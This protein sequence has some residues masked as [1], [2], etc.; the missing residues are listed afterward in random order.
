LKKEEVK[1]ENIC[2]LSCATTIEKEIVRMDGIKD[3]LIEYN[4]KTMVA[5]MS[6]K[7]DEEKTDM[8]KID[9]KAKLVISRFD[10]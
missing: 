4:S 10:E 2:C 8:D 9:E 5:T 3:A 1:Y 7:Y 6:V